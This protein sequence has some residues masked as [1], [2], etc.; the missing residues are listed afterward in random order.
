MS[1]MGNEPPDIGAYG[2]QSF[3]GGGTSFTLS[4]P[5]TTATV[6]LFIEGV[7]QT[8]VD[9][10]SVSGVTLTTTAT[11][12]SGT[13]NVTVQY[14]GDVV[15]FG[16]PSD[17]SVTTAKIQDDAVTSD[18]LANSINTEIAANTAKTG[19]TSG[20]ASAITANTAKVTNA[21]HTGDV[22]GATALTIATGAVETAM[23]ADDAVTSAKMADS[24]FLANRNLIINGQFD[25][26]Q[27][28]TSHSTSASA[29]GYGADRWRD[30]GY[31]WT[32]SYTRQTF[33]N[34]QTDVPDNPTY[35]LRWIVTG[36]PDGFNAFVQRIEN[37]PVNRFS[38]KT[39]TVS[40]W[41]RSVSGTLADG[42]IKQYGKSSLV[43]SG[44]DNIGAITTTWQKITTTGTLG[45]VST[46]SYTTG[47]TTD[48]S[49]TF[50][51]GVDIANWQVEIGSVATPFEQK[52][53]G[54]VLA[55]CQRYYQK[56]YNTSVAPGTASAVGAS[57]GLAIYST[58]SQGLGT[59]WIATMRS[60]PTVTLYTPGGT[61]GNVSNTANNADIAT[62]AGDIGDSGFQYC[63]GSLPNSAASGYRFHWTADAEL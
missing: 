46:S 12:P 29:L 3:D 58:G 10:Y 33:T 18:K 41:I 2:V 8:P 45:T 51:N 19:I 36:N 4:K 56:S 23:I 26:W 24:A 48:Q 1:Y 55:D 44:T 13:D 49:T 11:T 20:Q 59:R 61:S 37:N 54:Q 5:S 50:S 43:G 14:L 15:D 9:A 27:R 40:F 42:V 30:E 35:Y 32:G 47:L 52:S 17:D 16:E 22:T 31:G 39:I 62:T 34:G 53:F 38:G 60:T 21:T 28:G 57:S 6:L 25:I 63:S 7:R